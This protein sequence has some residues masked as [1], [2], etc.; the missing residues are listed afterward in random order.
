MRSSEPS[1]L[2]E[3][4]R[5]PLYWHWETATTT[6]RLPGIMIPFAYVFISVDLTGGPGLGGVLVAASM[7]AGQVSAPFC[8]R[9]ID[10][11][12]VRTWG[13]VLL[14]LGA[15]GQLIIA[16]AFVSRLSSWLNRK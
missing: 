4:V 14:L 12:G 3:L 5:L 1:P 7:V 6:L 10:R 2:R 16:L 9:L 11:L 15:A 13:P 8:G